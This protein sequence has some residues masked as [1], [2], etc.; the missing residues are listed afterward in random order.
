MI[1]TVTEVFYK[2]ADPRA[3]QYLATKLQNYGRLSPMQWL[4]VPCAE[5][6]LCFNPGPAREYLTA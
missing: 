2:Y 1:T 3:H 6:D 5:Q 4:E